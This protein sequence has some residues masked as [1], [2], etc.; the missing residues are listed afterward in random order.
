MIVIFQI[1]AVALSILVTLFAVL[2]FAGLI[3]LFTKGN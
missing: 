1:L 3:A 2:L